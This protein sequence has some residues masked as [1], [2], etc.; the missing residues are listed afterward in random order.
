MFRIHKCG[1][2]S[3]SLTQSTTCPTH[4]RA[5]NFWK[6]NGCGSKG[7][8]GRTM[9]R[10]FGNCTHRAVETHGNK[11]GAQVQ[12]ENV[13]ISTTQFIELVKTASCSKCSF[14]RVE[15]I[16]TR[17]VT[18][19]VVCR[20]QCGAGC[21][22]EHWSSPVRT[23]QGRPIAQVA[24]DQAEGGILAGL[25][26]HEYSIVNASGGLKPVGSSTFNKY[27]GQ[28]FGN[29]TKMAEDAL[30]KNL[31]MEAEATAH[32]E[33]SKIG[34][35][36]SLL[37]GLD[38]CWDSRRN[39]LNS[40]TTI[41]GMTTNRIIGRVSLNRATLRNKDGYVG[42]SKNMECIGL[43]VWL[44]YIKTK[45]VDNRQLTIS[46][47]V[48]D[49]DT[50]SKSLIMEE[51]PDAQEILDFNHVV[52]SF[53]KRVIKQ[54]KGFGELAGR[55]LQKAVR[56]AHGAKELEKILKTYPDHLDGDHSNCTRSCPGGQA[57]K[58][59][60]EKQKNKLRDL[61]QG[62]VEKALRV[63]PALRTNVNE[64]WHSSMSQQRPKRFH[65]AQHRN[66]KV[67]EAV[68]KREVGLSSFSQLVEH[69]SYTLQEYLDREQ[70]TRKRR[71][72]EF[73]T[74]AHQN[75]RKRWRADLKELHAKD[76]S[77]HITYKTMGKKKKKSIKI[78]RY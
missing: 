36:V 7:T 66:G 24:V 46:E 35:C 64:S 53:R 4:K 39:A 8:Y 45:C 44:Q 57:K 54:L 61:F 18:G 15:I 2:E 6:C 40:T 65:Y 38:G 48:H 22:Y 9:K 60:T 51:F 63:K 37:I 17:E 12:Q 78:L 41:C 52:V 16:N 28:L 1:C 14:P 32:E 73:Q 30:E 5:I 11:K 13:V 69:P 26:Y 56:I 59:M 76:G 29:A 67:D 31:E 10:H 58:K 42:P 34:L 33:D 23:A 20:V 68:V 50:A 55:C 71:Y 62:V 19:A 75:R 47:F 3:T 21:T 43:Q 74:E 25:N 27:E 70:K 77:P 49:Q 72:R